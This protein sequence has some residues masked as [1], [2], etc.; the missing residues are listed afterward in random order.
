MKTTQNDQVLKRLAQVGYVDNLW[1]IKN[2]IWR[3]GAR[4]KDLRNKGYEFE[5]HYLIK[6]GKKTKVYSYELV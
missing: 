5:G 3:L 2:G 4:I 1:A 6:K